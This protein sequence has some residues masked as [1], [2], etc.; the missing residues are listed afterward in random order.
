[1]P[2]DLDLNLLGWTDRAD[3]ATAGTF[4]WTIEIDGSGVDGADEPLVLKFTDVGTD[5]E[6]EGANNAR[7]Q[8]FR[9]P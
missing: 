8:W 6:V 1:M 3:D 2:A 4:T 5:L 9:R 7:L